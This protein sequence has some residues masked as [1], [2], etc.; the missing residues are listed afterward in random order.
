MFYFLKFFLRS[1]F[2]GL[3]HNKP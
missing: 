2:G 1:C 3:G